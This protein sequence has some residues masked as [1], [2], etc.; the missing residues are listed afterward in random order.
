[1]SAAS[2]Y[3]RAIR[4]PV[5]LVVLGLLLVMDQAGKWAFRST[6]PCLLIVLGVLILLERSGRVEGSREPGPGGIPQ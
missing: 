2:L 3:F 1:M 6:W 4:G 5:I